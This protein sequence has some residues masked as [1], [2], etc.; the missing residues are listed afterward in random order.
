MKMNKKKLEK[1]SKLSSG[2][3]C[4][5]IDETSEKKKPAIKSHEKPQ[6]MCTFSKRINEIETK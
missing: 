3:I 6:K 2:V 1:Y 4:C 5:G